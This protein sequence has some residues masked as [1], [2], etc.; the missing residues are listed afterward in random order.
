MSDEEIEALVAVH[1]EVCG[2]ALSKGDAQRAFEC[3]DAAVALCERH[4]GAARESPVRGLLILINAARRSCGSGQTL[5]Q[6]SALEGR[7]KQ[8]LRRLRAHRQ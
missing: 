8:L 5:T 7:A 4:P 1:V 6:L 3:L 2:N